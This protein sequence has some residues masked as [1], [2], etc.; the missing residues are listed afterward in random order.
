MSTL[1]V[2]QNFFSFKTA[3]TVIYYFCVVCWEIFKIALSFSWL[4]F[5]L[6][7]SGMCLGAGICADDDW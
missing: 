5:L 4:I 3:K 2:K 6:V 7:F 1:V